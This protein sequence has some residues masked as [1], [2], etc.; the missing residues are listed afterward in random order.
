MQRMR[1]DR[2]RE[3]IA[4]DRRAGYRPFMVIGT[5]GSVATGAVDPLPEIAALCRAEGVV[6]PRGRR[7]R[8]AG[9]A[10]ARRAAGACAR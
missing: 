1:M 6:V 8:R 2:L 7:V 10:G 5:G 3:R 9:R 4:E